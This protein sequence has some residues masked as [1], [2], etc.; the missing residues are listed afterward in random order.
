MWLVFLSELV[1]AKKR[2]I[3]QKNLFSQCPFK[4][5]NLQFTNHMINFKHTKKKSIFSLP[6]QS[7]CSHLTRTR[8]RPCSPQYPPRSPSCSTWPTWPSSWAS[9]Y[10][11]PPPWTSRCPSPPWTCICCPSSPWTCICTPCSSC[12]CT[13]QT[14]SPSNCWEAPTR[15]FH[16][17]PLYQKLWRW[18]QIAFA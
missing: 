13:S 18:I 15:M 16:W 3:K 6:A 9:C 8:S 10:R 2:E 12:P 17:T 14:P 4:R 5:S 11:S 1:V 7:L